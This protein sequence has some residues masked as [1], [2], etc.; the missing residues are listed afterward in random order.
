M[1]KALIALMALALVAAFAMPAAAA[2]KSEVSFGGYVAFETWVMDDD[3]AMQDLDADGSWDDGRYDDTDTMWDIDTVCSRFNATFKR[4]D[5]TAF[6]EMRPRAGADVGFRHWYAEWN[7][8]P[9]FLLIGQT[10]LPS[11]QPISS[12]AACCAAG[13]IS[14]FAGDSGSFMARAPMIRLRFPFSVG[15]FVMAFVDPSQSGSNMADEFGGA[16]QDTDYTLPQL[17]AAVNLTFGPVGLNFFG[18]WNEYEEVYRNQNGDNDPDEDEFDIESWVLG[19]NGKFT[20]GPFSIA[21]AGWFGE[22]SAAGVGFTGN[23]VDRGMLMPII[24]DGG[25][26]DLWL[27]GVHDTDDWGAYINITFKLNDMVSFAAGGG[28]MEQDRSDDQIG[29]TNGD[30][31]ENE[32]TAW[33]VNSTITIAEGFTITPEI[34]EFDYETS[35]MDGGEPL[36]QGDEMYYGIW[37]KMNF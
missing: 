33:F 35:T 34:G 36:D 18:T 13:E 12:S 6:V 21:L 27:D 16:Q 31:L 9:G 10:W 15:Q 28:T 17:E 37:W 5:F 24:F 2:E 20:A 26:G 14:T 32:C 30:E 1:K 29:G 23:A 11:F 8:G 7:F 19:G 22:N 4:E 3:G 25:D